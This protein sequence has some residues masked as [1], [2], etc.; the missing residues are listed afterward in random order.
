MS[1]SS[2]HQVV[3]APIQETN[4]V[5]SVFQ[6]VQRLHQ[7]F[8]AQRR[9][10]VL[11]ADTD[12]QIRR[13]DAVVV[14][15]LNAE[16]VKVVDAFSRQLRDNYSLIRPIPPSSPM[17]APAAAPFPALFGQGLAIAAKPPAQPV[18]AK[19]PAQ[20]IAV[21]PAA[22]PIG[23]Q[24][25]DAGP[26]APPKAAAKPPAYLFGAKP[27]AQPAAQPI[28]A[29]PA[30]PP[31]AAPPIAAKPA[32]IPAAQPVGGKPAAARIPI[33][34]IDD[35]E[36]EE[37]ARVVA[38]LN[39]DDFIS[40]HR[41][42]NDLNPPLVFD[43]SQYDDAA[44]LLIEEKKRGG[45]N[46][47]EFVTESFITVNS[48]FAW[49]TQLVNWN[50]RV[51]DS[52]RDN[53]VR[54]ATNENTQYQL[55]E[56]DFFNHWTR[57]NGVGL[58]QYVYGHLEIQGPLPEEIRTNINRQTRYQWLRRMIRDEGLRQDVFA[59]I[60]RYMD[61]WAS[62]AAAV[63]SKV[64]E[65]KELTVPQL[66]S[67]FD[68][69]TID[70]SS[71]LTTEFGQAVNRVFDKVDTEL[72]KMWD[73]VQTRMGRTLLTEAKLLEQE[74]DADL[75]MPGNVGGLTYGEHVRTM[76][77]RLMIAIMR[78]YETITEKAY[79][80][81]VQAV[82][83]R[84]AKRVQK[85]EEAK[86]YAEQMRLVVKFKD[87]VRRLLIEKKAIDTQAAVQIN[88][89]ANEVKGGDQVPMV[90]DQL[91][92]EA[93]QV[94]E[95]V[96]MELLG[97]VDP[98]KM[99]AE[100]LNRIAD[101]MEELYRKYAV[102]KRVNDTLLSKY[103]DAR[104]ANFV[105]K[106]VKDKREI[107]RTTTRDDLRE[108]DKLLA[109]SVGVKTAQYQPKINLSLEIDE[110][111]RLSLWPI[112]RITNAAHVPRAYGPL[113]HFAQMM[114]GAANT[115]LDLI[116]VRIFPD[117]ESGSTLWHLVMGRVEDEFAMY[118]DQEA[119]EYRYER[120]TFEKMA[121]LRDLGRKAAEKP[122]D[123]D[124]QQELDIERKK[125]YMENN[126]DYNDLVQ[127]PPLQTHARHRRNVVA[128]DNDQAFQAADLDALEE[129]LMALMATPEQKE[130]AQKDLRQKRLLQ[131]R[132][133]V[134]ALR[135][136]NQCNSLSELLRY[137]PEF[138]VPTASYAVM[139]MHEFI[140]SNAKWRNVPLHELMFA[141]VVSL[142]FAA[143]CGTHMLL[144]AMENSNEKLDL[145]RYEL[146]RK[147]HETN[148]FQ[149][150]GNKLHRKKEYQWET[151][152]SS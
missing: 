42:V 119:Q 12:M 92:E 81:S 52:F 90:V 144:Y 108:L 93:A 48:L 5:V 35:D 125:M 6:R 146:A 31:N 149:F 9:R 95:D 101:Y 36:E 112:Q 109:E 18:I 47:D 102:L 34:P 77:G 27:A 40:V 133:G 49:V 74:R 1:A 139:Q 115:N 29:G 88:A 143:L 111:K 152:Y 23:A 72:E 99:T 78:A 21:K 124:L 22:Q 150:F 76:Y 68:R 30:A 58:E 100:E 15:P 53:L 85:E 25:I 26:V 91:D 131:I 55:A 65:R 33:I 138:Y 75:P 94:N 54:F 8:D 128:T 96:S 10:Q 132:V 134:D 83:E 123:M 61:K 4:D 120:Y 38:P 19:P 46:V 136:L 20:P 50:E 37:K 116:L 17:Q 84:E 113:Y 2:S 39:L 127:G 106:F 105:R 3:V 147:N 89:N 28:D 135:R 122:L 44:P 43:P 57:G 118:N 126:R 140:K 32:A 107:H 82:V 13:A 148:A 16:D 117:I 70:A 63:L 56:T 145:N 104:I 73:Q 7:E 86:R 14:A 59:P 142:R 67:V 64:N 60:H 151:V 24:P 97:V 69:T 79:P 121:K 41:F 114:A 130:E 98:T 62:A 141:D 80:E 51:F 45:D 71:R 87:R 103:Q 129:K 11:P 66:L 110:E 137:L